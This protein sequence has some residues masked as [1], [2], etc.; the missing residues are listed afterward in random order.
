MAR[1]SFENWFASNGWTPFAFQRE[2]WA[3]YL[4]G[5][6]GLIHAPTG[7]GKTQAAWGGALLEW[8]DEVERS[9]VKARK[10]PDGLRVLWIT[11]LRA[12][13]N[14]TAESLRAP[15]EGMNLP[16]TVELRTGDTSSSIK[17]RQRTK[18]PTALV[19]TPES[20]S[21]L[22]SYDNARELFSDVRLVVMDEWHELLGNK[23]GVQAQLGLA[24]VFAMSPKLRIWGLSATLGNLDHAMR[25]LLGSFVPSHKH[26]MIHAQEPKQIEVETLRPSEIDRFPRAGHLG[27]ALLP[28]VRAQI[29]RARTTL[30]FTNTRSQAEIWFQELLRADPDLLGAIALHHGSL[31]RGVRE[32]VEQLIRAERL[33]AVV[34]TSS[35]DLGVDFPTVDQVIQ[36]GSPKGLA[37]L[38]QRAGRSGHQPGKVSRIIGVPTNAMELVEFAAA[39]AA[40]SEKQLESRESP[41]LVLDV[42]AQHLVTRAMGGGF[43]EATMREEVQRTDAF[44]NLTDEAWTWTMRFVDGGGEALRAYPEYARLARDDGSQ[45]YAVASAAIAKRH[46]PS[47]GTITSDSA[48][49]VRF[50]NGKLLGTIEESFISR[51]HPGQKF[52]FAGRVL[53]LIRVRQLTAEVKP[54]RNKRGAVPRWAGGRSPLSTQLADAVRD[55]LAEAKAGQF[56]GAEM[57]LVRP[58]L[59]IQASW[60]MIPGPDE[61][62]IEL[63]RSRD[64]Y[65]AFLFPLA[66]RLVHEGLSSLLALRA[67]RLRPMSIVVTGNDWGIELL[68]SHALPNDEPSWRA[69]LSS[70]G[71]LADL[72]EC[73]NATQLARRRF[74]EIARIAGLIQTGFPGENRSSKYLQAS[75][76]LFYDVFSQY[77]PDNLLLDQAK[78]EVLEQELEFK[79]LRT[80]LE[81]AAQQT[82]CIVQTEQFSPLAFPI[83]VER[84]RSQEVS[85]EPWHARIERMAAQLEEVAVGTTEHCPK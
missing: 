43:D 49:Q 2:A 26:R 59:N 14:D 85:S 76:D 81:R 41:Q 6:S 80:A 72:L 34:C 77:D 84:I 58:L 21:V 31:D 71:L 5:E 33:R 17:T 70:E 20:L 1:A 54:A 78:R 48:V 56:C 40:I 63:T 24:S 51:L 57:E 44:Q 45:R 38:M 62:L 9:E 61:L 25:V 60:S 66:G 11:P 18:P 82:L 7:L 74:R 83:W 8:L 10:K 50:A 3:A 32:E 79:R 30:V 53:E 47:I 46:R 4:A 36:I 55:R 68:A 37:R 69:L 29:H 23:R 42:L 39:R 35:L 75:S 73:V 12:L 19:T 13:A 64:G 15:I 52:V 67:T 27:T 28:Q 16:W 22:L 65:H